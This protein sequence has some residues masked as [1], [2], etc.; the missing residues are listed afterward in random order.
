MTLVVWA[1]AAGFTG[2]F[3]CVGMCGPLVGMHHFQAGVRGMALYQLGR[4]VAYVLLGGLAGSLGLSLTRGASHLQWQK[5]LVLIFGAGMMVMGIYA[6]IKGGNK[7]PALRLQFLQKYLPESWFRGTWAS[8]TW[9]VLSGLLPCGYLHGFV[10]ASGSTGSPWVAMAFMLAFW[11]GTTPALWGS[12]LIM[13]T[14]GRETSGKLALVTPVFLIVFGFLALAGKWVIPFG[15]SA[16]CL[17]LP[18]P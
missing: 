10:L 2:S 14:L 16:T 12:G 18:G 4:A 9:G 17:P 11:A 1:L 7:P 15:S 8:L 13:K 3:H 6:L 5:G